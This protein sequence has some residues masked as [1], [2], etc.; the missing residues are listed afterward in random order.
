MKPGQSTFDERLVR[1][2]KGKTLNASDVVLKREGLVN[3]SGKKRWIHLDMLAAGG[4]AGGIAG[5]LFAMNVGVFLMMTLTLDTLYGLIIADYVMAAYI[6]AVAIAPVGF[7]MSQ[8]FARSNPRGWQFWMG[9]LAGV[10]A[11]NYSD[12]NALYYTLYPPGA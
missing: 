7:V 8:I 11:A 9:Y 12:L 5:T 2:N 4:M 10:L 3:K 1:I 6:G